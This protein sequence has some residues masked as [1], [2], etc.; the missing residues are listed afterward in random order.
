MNYVQNFELY[1]DLNVSEN[2]KT[3]E[4]PWAESGGGPLAQCQG[5]HAAHL[6]AAQLVHSNALGT[7]P[8]RAETRHGPRRGW[9]AHDQCVMAR[10][11]DGGATLA[12]RRR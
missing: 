7:Q 12:H 11:H 6:P 8:A 3:K 2:R 9:H 4:C 5:A 10:L 1:K